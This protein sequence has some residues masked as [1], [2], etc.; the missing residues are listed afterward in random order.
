[1]A[2][3][4]PPDSRAA[5]PADPA[6]ARSARAA[7][8]SPAG[9][10]EVLPG[11]DA[12]PHARAVLA[13]GLPPRGEPSHAYLF[14]GP[15][16]TGKRA[17]ARAFATAL[18]AD[19]AQDP[20]RWPSGWR[21]ARH[22]D[23][24]WV[25]PSGAAEMLVADIEEPVV[26][27]AT[28]T[29]FESSRRVFVIEAVD[30]MNDQ[31]ANRMLKT[32]E[33]PAGFVHLLLLT[34][35]R[36]DVMATIASRCQHVRFD[37]LPPA[38]MAEGLKLSDAERARARVRRWRSAMRTW[39]RA[40]PARRGRRCAARPRTWRARRSPAPRRSVRGR[41][42]SRWRGMPARPPQRRRRRGWPRSSSCC[43][44]RSASATNAKASTHGAAASGA[45]ARSTLD[46]ALRLAE[47]WL[48]DMLCIC[49]GAPEL[50]YA[51]D[52]R[53][54]LEHDAAA[55][56]GDG[57]RVRAGIELV[58]ETRLSLPLNVSEELALE[59][60]GLPPGGAFPRVRR[61][62]GA[63]APIGPRLGSKP[64]GVEREK[65]GEL[66]VVRPVEVG[67]AGAEQ[68]EGRRSARP[69][70]RSARGCG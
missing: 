23:L 27:A 30:T 56:H 45:C 21:A 11:I 22:P 24:T 35:R 64:V 65:A 19:G 34:D 1:M 3:V 12:H 14:H 66:A 47:L 13:G 40:W 59:A 62:S 8:A 61:S 54:E 38:R 67:R 2:P 29:P 39:P 15:A 9:P 28:R 69:A 17:V 58:G 18:L 52:R 25:T 57:A 55:L 4:T 6:A 5:A 41:G 51:V 31:A 37:P 43:R 70:A 20:G 49:E 60:L 48:R 68:A 36:E 46:L 7:A 26:A 16:G 32:L 33:E 50:I 10:V 63:H 53:A 42:C 44:A